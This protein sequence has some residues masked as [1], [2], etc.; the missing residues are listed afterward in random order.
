L[1]PR[2]RRDEDTDLVIKKGSQQ[3]SRALYDG[4]PD[5][6]VELEEEEDADKLDEN[7]GSQSQSKVCY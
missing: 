7:Q 4:P 6:I 2:Q 3:A 5:Q 1:V